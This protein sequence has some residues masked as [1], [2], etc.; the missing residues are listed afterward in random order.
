[1]TLAMIAP[2]ETEMPL[3][4]SFRYSN[5]E[6]SSYLLA[7]HY[8]ADAKSLA[9]LPL[10]PRGNLKLRLRLKYSH[11]A[12]MKLNLNP[13]RPV[14]ISVAPRKLRILSMRQSKAILR[15]PESK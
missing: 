7:V 8:F 11:F 3:M 9:W 14:V 6:Q 4:G 2:E 12:Y 10:Q 13:A 15:L 5:R 1:M